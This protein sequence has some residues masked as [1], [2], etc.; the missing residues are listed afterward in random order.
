M[1]LFIG[2]FLLGVMGVSQAAE[3]A[4]CT[5]GTDINLSL[6][7][8]KVPADAKVGDAIGLFPFGTPHAMG[9]TYPNWLIQIAEASSLAVVNSPATGQTYR[10][11]GLVMPVFASN[12]PG[13]GFA[14]AA[15][16]PNTPLRAISDSPIKLHI[17]PQRK[18]GTWGLKG[19][20][21]L[22]I[23]GQVSGG[24]LGPRTIARF[25]VSPADVSGPGF[26]AVNL[27]NAVIAAPIKPTC[28]VSTRTLTLALG[29]V[30]RRDF[31]GVGSHAGSVTDNLV[32]NCAGATEERTTDVLITVTDQTV[33]TNRSGVLSLSPASKATGV[34]LQLL[35]GGQLILYGA[36]SASEGN[37]NQWL[38]GSIGNGALRIPLT[39]RY[40][41]TRDNITPG[42]ANGVATFT[43][44]YR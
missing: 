23:T 32:I 14:I 3:K 42:S 7:T 28:S 17:A 11:L 10:A 37:P 20:L 6:P 30:A 1:R 29:A 41:Q 40:I 18:P 21:Y 4:Q 38:A 2:L 31:K 13:L 43:L 19:R 26:L 22:V 5:P 33:P 39:A 44:S 34:G 9:C 36:D 12:I 8:I 27:G 15:Q 35:S 16:D 25:T 24:T